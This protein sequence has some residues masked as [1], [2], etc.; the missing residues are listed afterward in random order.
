MAELFSN[1]AESTTAGAINNTTDPVT[2]SVQPGDGSRFPA[3][4][5]GSTDYFHAVVDSG[6]IVEILRCQRNVDAITADRAQ[7]G[8]L[9]VAHTAG[10]K[11]AHVLTASAI[12][13]IPAYPQK[14]TLTTRGDLYVRNSTGL[15]V[16]KATGGNGTVLTADSTDPE[17]LKWATPSG[18]GGGAGV[19]WQEADYTIYYDGTNYQ[20]R[21][22]RTTVI[23]YTSNTSL[24]NVFNSAASALGNSGGVIAF[25]SPTGRVMNTTAPLV[26]GFKTWVRGSHRGTRITATG[27]GWST[28]T[29]VTPKAVIDANGTNEV[30]ID[31]LTIDCGG[32]AG[33]T[34][35]LYKRGTGTGAA[36]VTYCKVLDP[37]ISGFQIGVKN[38]TDFSSDC[39]L[40][41]NY[42]YA[43]DGTAEGLPS[44]P[45]AL[46]AFAYFDG[47]NH[48]LGGNNAK[49]N[50]ASGYGIYLEAGGV[51]FIGENH[52]ANNNNTNSNGLITV[53]KGGNNR[54]IGFYIDNIGNGPAIDLAPASTNASR[55][56]IAN[57]WIHNTLLVDNATPCFRINATTNA[58]DGTVI[59]GNTSEATT[60]THPFSAMVQIV[61]STQSPKQT[62]T[63]LGN[64]FTDCTTFLTGGSGTIGVGTNMNLIG[65][66]KGP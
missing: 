32:R 48:F 34:G 25:S 14:S 49:I 8:T 43:T 1:L 38:T 46:C 2:F 24:H 55:T 54:F 11:F 16:R 21:N 30:R 10:V 57:N 41:G 29:L 20:A 9:K 17:G 22:E 18:G 45:G 58:V 4:A 6:T 61:G 60:P 42:V 13:Q 50:A 39:W 51:H 52:L 40:L 47:D 37:R 15:I 28:G 44:N 62:L 33:T 5:V 59:T 36:W 27:S 7:E 31:S 56:I 35:I 53:A 12:Q 64:S 3:A 23:D 19:A 63:M 26:P 66:T 65:T